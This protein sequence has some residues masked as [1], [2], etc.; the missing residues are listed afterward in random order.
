MRIKKDLLYSLKG[1]KL[2]NSVASEKSVA[3]KEIK[4]W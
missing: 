3:R 1:T 4:A 2:K